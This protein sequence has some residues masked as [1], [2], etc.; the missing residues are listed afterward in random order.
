[1]SS[2]AWCG[3]KLLGILQKFFG[4]RKQNHTGLINC[5]APGIRG[6]TY[7]GV[8]RI[9]LNRRGSCCLNGLGVK[10]LSLRCGRNGFM[11]IV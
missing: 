7:D 2:N 4:D 3:C 1:M 10:D 5:G 8:Y 11:N 6:E 9:A